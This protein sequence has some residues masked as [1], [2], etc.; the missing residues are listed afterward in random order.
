V[1]EMDSQVAVALVRL[2]ISIDLASESEITSDFAVALQGDAAAVFD[3]LTN[4]GRHEIADIVSRMAAD[5]TIAVRRQALEEF[6]E[7]YGLDDDD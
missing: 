1:V 6:A 2:L 3:S 7:A 5:E 4:E